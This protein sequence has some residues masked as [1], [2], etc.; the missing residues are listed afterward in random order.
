MIFLFSLGF[1]IC[2]K[3]KTINLKESRFY[4]I[5]LCHNVRSLPQRTENKIYDSFGNNQWLYWQ[6]FFSEVQFGNTLLNV[7]EYYNI[8]CE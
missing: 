2:A 3:K 5:S 7:S 1:G 8:F 6:R 4:K